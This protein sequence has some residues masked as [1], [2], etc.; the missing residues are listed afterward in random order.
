MKYTTLV[1]FLS[2]LVPCAFGKDKEPVI[3]NLQGEISDSQCAFN[4]H[5]LD[6]THDA[7]IGKGDFGNDSK[8]CTRQCVKK[9]GGLYVLVVKEQVYRLDDQIQPE[10]FSGKKV[11]LSGTML[12]AKTQTLHVLSIEAIR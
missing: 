11:K 8:S 5:S 4:V 10:Q 6:R 7:M 2:L 9:M 12:D 1:L 3:L